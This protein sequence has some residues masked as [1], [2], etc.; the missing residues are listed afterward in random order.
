MAANLQCD[1]IQ[2]FF[3]L[4]ESMYHATNDNGKAGH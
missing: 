1:S 2:N 3:T 4:K